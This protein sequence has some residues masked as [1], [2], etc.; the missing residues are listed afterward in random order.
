LVVGGINKTEDTKIPW[1]KSIEE[2]ISGIFC[3]Y[4]FP[5]F[6]NFPAGHTSDNRAFYIGKHAEI[7]FK[8][9]KAKLSYL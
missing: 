9:N 3:K 8:G 5:L 6:F 1:G 4:E 7:I 2:T